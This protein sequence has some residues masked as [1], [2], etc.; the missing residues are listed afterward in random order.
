MERFFATGQGKKFVLSP[1]SRSLMPN[2]NL[3]LI[4][5]SFIYTFLD[6]LKAPSH[7]SQG[8]DQQQYTKRIPPSSKDQINHLRIHS[9]FDI[10]ER[11]EIVPDLLASKPIV[12][13]I[14]FFIFMNWTMSSSNSI[15]FI[16]TKQCDSPYD[17]A[18][19]FSS[20]RHRSILFSSSFGS[21]KSFLSPF[22][23]GFLTL[24]L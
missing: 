24:L 3:I 22:D 9:P 8:A 19:I 5:R 13:A 11:R 12:P 23:H 16:T 21:T 20:P 6:C 1:S 2:L 10:M 15:D 18:N 14:G 7:R 17:A 4:C